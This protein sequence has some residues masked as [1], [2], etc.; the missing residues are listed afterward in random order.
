L[1]ILGIE[2]SC[3]ETAAAVVEDGETVLSSV[4]ASQ[5]DTHGKYG[6][7]VPELASREHLRAVVPV[8]RSALEQA[9]C[10]YRDLSAVAATEGP[11]LVGSL[12]VGLTFAKSLCFA[13]KLPLIGVNHLEGH[14]YAVIMEARQQR[15][16]VEF[17][18]L[19]LVVSGGH[20]HLFEIPE[21]MEYRLL[22]KTRDDAAGEAFD[23][24]AKL[25]GFPYPGG[26]IVDRLAAH[27]NP[28]AVRFSRVKMKKNRLD[29]SFSGLKTAVL[30]WFEKQDMDE[31]V[32]VR[33]QLFRELS[34]PTEEQWLA[35]T[36]QKTLDLLASFQATVIDELLRRA[37]E[38][39]DMI[40]ARS[41]VISGGV[42][43]NSGLR[44]EA[45][46]DLEYPVH[47]PTPG[48]STDN[49][50]MIAAAAFPR[51]ERGEFS[52]YSLRARANLTLAS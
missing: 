15:A 38:S 24:V 39:A 7:V 8:V 25:L 1:R 18:A 6:G 12:L 37:A 2:S 48:L 9:G 30:R 35:V 14:I 26:P 43:C 13:Q 27:G 44:R 23:K 36:P 41:I 4:V 32:A 40:G 11:G 47:F 50:A 10:S 52:D 16:P 5:L 49:A 34:Q 3:D 17:P 28:K 20:T 42:A 33:R 19:A 45:R 51:L 31:E 46:A 29:F 22:G 21:S